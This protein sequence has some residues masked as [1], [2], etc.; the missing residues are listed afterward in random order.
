M[1]NQLQ[2]FKDETSRRAYGMTA[3]EAIEQKICISCKKPP[4]FTSEAGFR[5]YRITGLCEPCFDRITKDLL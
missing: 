4:T 5:E 1:S 2:Q 3:R